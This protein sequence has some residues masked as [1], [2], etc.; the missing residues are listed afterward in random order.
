[1]K[2]FKRIFSLCLVLA[3]SVIMF[4]SCNNDKSRVVATYDGDKYIYE[5]EKVFSDFYNLNRYF[6]SYETGDH[7]EN[8]SEYNTILSTAVK[9]TIMIKVLED[10]LKAKNYSIDMDA[11]VSEAN[12]DIASF[13]SFYEGGF[14]QFCEDWNLSDEVFF[15]YNK[16]EALKK[17]A[18]SLVE[19][20]VN[21]NEAL[22]YYNDNPEKYFKVPHYDVNTIFL[23][24][25][26]PSNESEKRKAYNDS[27]LYIQMLNSGRSWES[28]KE[29][30]FM[31][32]NKNHGMIFTEYLSCLNHVSMKYFLNIIDIETALKIVEDK[33]L[34]ENGMTFEEMFPGSFEEYAI[35]NKL[36][37]ET[38]E[39]NKALE[40]YISYASEIY[41]IEFEY[42]ITNY[43]QEGKTYYKPIY[44]AV[45]DSY[46]IV[47]FTRIEEENVTVTFD[48]A[49]EEIKEILKGE[50]REKALENYISRKMDDLKVQ[51][52]YK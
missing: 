13:N 17:K 45:Y 50:K 1:M 16:Y 5:D 46:V 27:L 18:E 7:S 37:P 39:Y 40:T 28:V 32:Y 36:Y 11:V 19:V 38:K 33:F 12:K 14:E 48:E 30:A 52:E 2:I 47:T 9:E 20:S 15:L 21:D 51:I 26:E 31:K 3:L 10:E 42:A 6:H 41:N 44:H 49:K 22:E 8:T 35:E 29:T 4:T 43:W 24:V 23:Q 34:E 25:L